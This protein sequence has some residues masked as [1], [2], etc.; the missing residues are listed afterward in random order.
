M[1]SHG[2]SVAR[3]QPRDAEP[4]DTNSIFILPPRMSLRIF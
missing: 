4:V 3:A 1:D 2:W